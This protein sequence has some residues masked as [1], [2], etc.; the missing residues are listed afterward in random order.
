MD[1]DELITFVWIGAVAFVVIAGLVVLVRFL[2]ERR[3]TKALGELADDMGWSFIADGRRVFEME[4]VL[5]FR[6]FQQGWRPKARNLLSLQEDRVGAVLF[7]YR[8][9]IGHGKHRRIRWQTVAATQWKGV[10][11]PDFFL[12]PRGLLGR[13]LIGT[14]SRD[15]TL[16]ANPLFTKRYKLQGYAEEVVRDFFS[17][18][19]IG[20]IQRGGNLC[21]EGGGQWLMM[22][23]TGERLSP[24]AIPEFHREVMEIAHAMLHRCDPHAASYADDSEGVEETI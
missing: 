12:E 3:R 18:D 4:M 2:I 21:I 24:K 23:R 1:K 7:D 20:A 17:E 14:G 11:F 15:I 16:P 19:V 5:T 10:F 6:L 9:V 22:Y 13:F 8:Y